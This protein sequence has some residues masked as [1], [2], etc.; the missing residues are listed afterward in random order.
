MIVFTLYV[1]QK[2]SHAVKQLLASVLGVVHSLQHLLGLRE[3]LSGL[4]KHKST[5]Q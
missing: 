4:H 2:I 1:V 3:E 5:N